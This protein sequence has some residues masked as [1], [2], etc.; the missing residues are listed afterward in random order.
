MTNLSADSI[1]L[2]DTSLQSIFDVLDTEDIPRLNPNRLLPNPTSS[3]DAFGLLFSCI[4]GTIYKSGRKENNIVW[5]ASD[6]F[7]HSLL[8]EYATTE[9]RNPFIKAEIYFT[10]LTGDTTF[11][12][13]DSRYRLIAFNTRNDELG[14]GRF[15]GGV[16]GILLLRQNNAHWITE[17]FN[18]AVGIYGGWQLSGMP[19]ISE[20]ADS[21]IFLQYTS[22]TCAAGAGCISDAEFIK[23]KNGKLD[24]LGWAG[25]LS[26]SKQSPGSN[27]TTEFIVNNPQKSILLKTGGYF[28][29]TCGDYGEV[30]EFPESIK[31]LWKR[32][33]SNGSKPFR[34]EWIREIST[35]NGKSKLL[36]KECRIIKWISEKDCCTGKYP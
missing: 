4:P 3:H 9:K 17:Y 24:R 25:F 23:Y 19:G 27:W 6:S 35:E 12:M 29:P 5:I 26:F 20:S 34:F 11:R 16:A 18:P 2:S 31:T 28:C 22:T 30:P 13:A 33:N 32:Y 7:S 1:V 8:A 15:I 21:G 36:E 10:T 14:L